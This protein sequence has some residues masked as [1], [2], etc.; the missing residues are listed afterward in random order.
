MTRPSRTGLVVGV[1]GAAGQ[2]GAAVCRVLVQT[3]GIRQVVGLDTRR[4]GVQGVTWRRAD[5]TDPGLAASLRRLD[6]LV[7]LALDVDPDSDRTA[8]RIA[9]NRAASIALAA[10]AAAAV[11]R[12]VLVTSARVYGAHADNPV[13]LPEDAPLRAQPENTVLGDLLETEALA[14]RTYPGVSVAVLRPALLV[15]PGLDHGAAGLLDG[16]RMLAVKG[17]RPHWQFCHVDDLAAAVATTVLAGLDGPLTVGSEGWLDQA[18]V[19]RVLDRRRIELPASVAFGTAARLHAIGVS[20]PASELSYLV[21]PWVVGS[22]RL[23][24]AGWKPVYSNLEALTAYA[25]GRP[26]G[27]RRLRIDAKGATAAAGATVALV[28]TAALIRQARRR[29]RRGS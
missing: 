7:H 2:L 1:T 28:G 11:R 10:A 6:A 16:P 12:V 13:P 21:H 18:E 23:R 24:D 17:A 25:S 26:V 20:T 4:P 9:N 19:E 29:K 14:T 27:P 8:Q 3:E 22:E 15:G 5:P